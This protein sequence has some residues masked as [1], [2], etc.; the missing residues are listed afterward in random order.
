MKLF[1]FLVFVVLSALSGHAAD[2]R[3]TPHDDAAPILARL[4]PGDVLE[5]GDGIFTNAWVLSGLEGGHDAPVTIRGSPG[6]V[7]RT[8]GARDAIVFWD[9]P[10][11]YVVLENL[12]VED[13]K[14]G[15]IVVFG[16]SDIT[17]RNC[18]IRD[19]GKWGIQT[20]MSQRVIVE[21]CDVSGSAME[22]GIY[23]STTDEPVARNCRIYRNHACGIHMNGDAREGG[24]GMITGA[25]IENNVIYSNGVSGGAAINMDGVELSGIYGNRVFDNLSGGIVSF[26]QNGRRGGAGNVIVSNTVVFAQDKGRFA[27][28][29]ADGSS[30][31]CVTANN[32]VCGRGPALEVTDD[33]LPGLKCTGNEYRSLKGPAVKVGRRA[34]TAEEWARGEK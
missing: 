31:T 28:R 23:F 34:Y 17:I 5:L 15:G 6:T 4:R 27:L 22:H 2:F 7:I 25:R 12:T 29:L 19:C 32:F 10:S 9:R 3:V 16:S 13:A 18:T 8:T 11:R 20:C 14:R 30:N 21:A 1:L 24:D 26:R 33:S